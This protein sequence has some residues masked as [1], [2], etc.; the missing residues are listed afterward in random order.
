[1]VSTFFFYSKRSTGVLNSCTQ[2][3][4]CWDQSEQKRYRYAL[5]DS[6]SSSLYRVVPTSN[7][8]HVHPYTIRKHHN[9]RAHPGP[10]SFAVALW[11]AGARRRAGRQPRGQGRGAWRTPW[12]ARPRT[13]SDRINK[14]VSYV[15][16]YTMDDVC[17]MAPNKLCFYII[18]V[19]S[20]STPG[21]QMLYF[22]PLIHRYLVTS[23]LLYYG[24]TW[25][26][27]SSFPKRALMSHLVPASVMVSLMAVF[28]VS[29]RKYS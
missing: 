5:E 2:N 9:L 21:T 24:S 16:Y 3:L 8:Q 19:E 7:I 15:L 13:G 23:L 28:V 14:Y 1:M 18:G 22:S 17:H 12:S 29:P 11:E 20:C 26:T 4:L 10:G 27:M 25:M 6:L